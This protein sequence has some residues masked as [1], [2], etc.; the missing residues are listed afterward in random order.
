MH[1]VPVPIN[2][3]SYSNSD[4]IVRR[5]EVTL[6]TNNGLVRCNMI[7]GTQK[8]RPPRGGIAGFPIFICS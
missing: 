4:I 1:S 6:G 5:S 8:E 2:V 3:R 7:G